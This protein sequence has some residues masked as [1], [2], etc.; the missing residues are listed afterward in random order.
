MF[1]QTEKSSTNL[2]Y[3]DTKIVIFQAHQSVVFAEKLKNHTMM[4]NNYWYLTSL[5]S[6]AE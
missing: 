5:T 2:S 4:S 3:K 6:V 1:Y